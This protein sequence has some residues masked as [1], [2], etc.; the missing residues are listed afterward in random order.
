VKLIEKSC[1][2]ISILRPRCFNILL[3]F[4]LI[5]SFAGQEINSRPRRCLSPKEGR[6]SNYRSR[7]VPRAQRRTMEG[8]S[9][10][11]RIRIG[12][13]LGGHKMQSASARRRCTAERG[14]FLLRGVRK[15][16]L[17]SVL[18]DLPRCTRYNELE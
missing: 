12:C 14:S 7:C 17:V 18:G 8:V 13:A 5:F 3:N 9:A 10:G 1:M 11:A 2:L 6:E 4:L 15:G 16:S